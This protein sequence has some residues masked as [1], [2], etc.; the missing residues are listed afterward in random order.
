MFYIEK[1]CNGLEIPCTTT[2]YHAIL[3]KIRAF[4]SLYGLRNYEIF[5]EDP[6]C[7]NRYGW[8]KKGYA[9]YF[10]GFETKEE[11]EDFCSKHF[12]DLKHTLATFGDE[13]TNYLIVEE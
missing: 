9:E 13:R 4:K 11:A 8:L 7:K 6:S 2:D 12:I 1:L 10:L 5:T 3:G